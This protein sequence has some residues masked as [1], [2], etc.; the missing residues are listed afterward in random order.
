[1]SRPDLNAIEAR[2]KAATTEHP[3]VGSFYIVRDDVPV[4]LAYARELEAIRGNDHAS[5]VNAVAV[6]Q[7]ERDAA[8]T[9]A[10]QAERLERL[11]CT[12]QDLLTNS[13]RRRHAAEGAR[14]QAERERDEARDLQVVANKSAKLRG[15]KLAEVT[16]QAAAMRGMLEWVA[17]S[18]KSCGEPTPLER[19]IAAAL[20]PDAGR[21]L[22]AESR[23]WYLADG[24]FE[25]LDPAEVVARRK[26]AAREL[27][28]LREVAD[29][30]RGFS[31]EW[32][33]TEGL[34]L[35]DA[36]TE[37]DRVLSDEPLR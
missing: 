18:L 4:L 27:A 37:L 22:L 3:C 13:E 12:N 35:R 36:L 15:E 24:T 14:E 19:T 5:K 7:E 34:R 30:A 31:S 6:V 28:A 9:R 25:E 32:R 2:A 11:V 20:A 21:A 33:Y 1:M 29:A 17:R 10:E 23:R 26:A 16:A 8:I